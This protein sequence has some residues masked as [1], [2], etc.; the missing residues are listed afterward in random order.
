MPPLII[1]IEETGEAEPALARAAEVILSGGLVAVPTESFYGLAANALDEAA[2]QR[3]LLV[4][5]IRENHPILTLIPSREA[6]PPYVRSI[7]PLAETLMRVFWPGGLTLVL[8]A[9]AVVPSVLTAGTGKIGVRLSSHPTAVGLARRVGLPIT[10]TS[11]N[12]TGSPPC[13]RA[14]DVLASLGEEVDLILDAGRT[15]GG[16]GSTVLDITVDPP[17]ILREGMVSVDQLRPFL[18]G[19]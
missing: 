14:E 10:G 9:S 4:K 5:Q 8:H 12:V 15:G 16:K 13:V 2:V 1:R 18:P 3:L 19:L 17:R 6:L 7:P 11:A